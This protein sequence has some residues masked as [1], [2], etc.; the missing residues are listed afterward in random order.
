MWKT[1]RSSTLMVILYE[2][3]LC[4]S[5][6]LIS[7]RSAC[8]N[9]RPDLVCLQSK[10]FCD[11]ENK[12][13]L[14]KRKKSSAF[15]IRNTHFNRSLWVQLC[16]NSCFFY[17]GYLTVITANQTK[18]KDHRSAI[19]CGIFLN[20]CKIIT[21]SAVTWLERVLGG[22]IIWKHGCILETVISA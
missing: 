4:Y 7:L 15:D 17:F 6:H 10:F 9:N 18:A 22:E 2:E 20:L 8:L 19:L 21:N 12:L 1:G 13:L 11:L 5:F 14:F 3:W 16:L